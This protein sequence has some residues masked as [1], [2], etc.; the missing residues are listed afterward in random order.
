MDNDLKFEEKTFE[1]LKKIT[2]LFNSH[3]D[4]YSWITALSFHIVGV[5]KGQNDPNLAYENFLEVLK[6][7]MAMEVCPVVES[8]TDSQSPSPDPLK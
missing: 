6:N 3:D 2:D 1:V 8:E 4:I 7:G 5:I